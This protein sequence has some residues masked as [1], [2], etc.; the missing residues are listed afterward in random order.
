MTAAAIIPSTV[1]AA[2]KYLDS[3]AITDS[4][5][6]QGNDLAISM[7]SGHG[8]WHAVQMTN[9]GKLPVT[10][11]HVYPGLVSV[12]N[13]TYDINGIFKAGPIV[14]EPG[15]KYLGAVSVKTDTAQEQEIPVG[16]AHQN[17]FQ[18]ATEYSHFG[19]IKPVVTMR[20]FFA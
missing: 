6:S 20:S 18:L 10:V 16:L 13:K 17:K 3:Q 1:N 19:E 12:D 15:K 5:L 8:R 9:T 11:K 14:I 2:A 4:E 7:V